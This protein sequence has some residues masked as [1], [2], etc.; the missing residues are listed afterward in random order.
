HRYGLGGRRELVGVF[1][2]PP[3]FSSNR[4]SDFPTGKLEF[5]RNWVLRYVRTR[6]R[7]VPF[8]W[9]APRPFP[10][11]GGHSVLVTCCAGPA[12]SPARL[13]ASLRSREAPDAGC[14]SC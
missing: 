1:A 4:I 10:R 13:R 3:P 14:R 11:R 12:S 5:G 8:R 6:H 2:E 9:P 7:K